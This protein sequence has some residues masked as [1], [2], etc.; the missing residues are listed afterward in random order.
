VFASHARFI[1]ES[2]RSRSEP[3]DDPLGAG[4]RYCRLTLIEEMQSFQ[5][6]PEQ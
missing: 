5:V 3:S 6:S 1:R 2:A 4:A